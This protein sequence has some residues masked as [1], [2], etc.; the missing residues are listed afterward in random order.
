MDRG[1]QFSLPSQPHTVFQSLCARC[2]SSP[3]SSTNIRASWLSCFVAA[4]LLVAA[5]LAGQR[6][7]FTRERVWP[8][9]EAEIPTDHLSNI[10]TLTGF[11][12]YYS[13]LF[14][15]TLEAC[16]PFFFFCLN[17]SLP[18]SKG[19]TRHHERIIHSREGT[20]P[21]PR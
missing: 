18:A 14:F 5:F 16:K 19:N 1:D 6:S 2:D 12:D 15:P 7:V 3:G 11:P 13:P 4:V 21:A 17:M 10:K 9:A 20:S 8:I